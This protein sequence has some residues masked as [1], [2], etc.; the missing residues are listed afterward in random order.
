MV[1]PDWH[2]SGDF[3]ET[4]NC[5]YICSCSTS[6]FVLPP[7][8]DECIAVLVFHIDSG[9]YGATLLD[10]RSVAMVVYTPE[11]PMITADWT[12]GLII[13]ERADAAQQEALTAIFSGRAGGPLGGLAPLITNFVGVESR[14]I[15][16]RKDGLSRSVTIPDAIDY[17]VEG[18]AN[19][20]QEGE[21][22]AID[23]PSHPAS[24]RPALARATRSH[25]HAF[26]LDWD[27]ESGRNNGHFAPFAWS[28]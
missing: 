12:L 25:L 3:C 20:M 23:D 2:L 18:F 14:P 1:T 6:N 16:F 15:Q 27:D 11:G 8:K 21:Y 22:L 10:D 28:A 13:D 9:S 7:N 5:F 4:C 19:P 17:A 24:A 26:G